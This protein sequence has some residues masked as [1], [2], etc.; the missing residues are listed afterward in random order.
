ML[1]GGFHR[2]VA[3]TLVEV[4]VRPSSGGADDVV[5]FVAGQ[6]GALPL[7]LAAGVTAASVLLAM[8]TVVTRGRSFAALAVPAR[9]RLVEQW[10]SSPLPP[11]RLY[12]RLVRS[13]VVYAAHEMAAVAT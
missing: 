9:A 5:D 10:S 11:A 3:A 1:N 2:A 8:I 4:D 12:V 13:L 7:H 6:L